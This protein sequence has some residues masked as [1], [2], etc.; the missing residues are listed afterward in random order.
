MATPRIA[1]GI[2][3]RDP[4]GRILLVRPTYKDG[5]DIPG[6]Y[7]EPGESPAEACHRELKEEIGLDRELGTL[8]VVDWAPHPDEGD[9]LLFVFDGGVMTQAET[10]SLIPDGEEIAEVRFHEESELD[11]L[12]PSRLSRRLHL[13]MSAART[14]QTMYAEHG[15][16]KGPGLRAGA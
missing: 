12:M 5:W 11:R 8:L 1:A 10:S 15:V 4:D 3:I 7:V 14:G 6:G 2:A 9:K 13:A 16:A